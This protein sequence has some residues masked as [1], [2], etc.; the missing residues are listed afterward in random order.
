MPAQ[1]EA[2]W[3]V[4]DPVTDQ[5]HD[6]KIQWF[7]YAEA[8]VT[9]DFRPTDEGVWMVLEAVHEG[10]PLGSACRLIPWSQ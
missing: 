8:E 10:M 9:T 4:T 1:F 2:T 3:K 5:T 6:L 7:R